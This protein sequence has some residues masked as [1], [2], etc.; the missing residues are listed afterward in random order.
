MSFRPHQGIIF[1]SCISSYEGNGNSGYFSSFRP[2]QGIIFF[3]PV[4]ETADIYWSENAKNGGDYKT[5]LKG[6]LVY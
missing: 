6:T 2:H 3:S 4:F 5:D 1:F